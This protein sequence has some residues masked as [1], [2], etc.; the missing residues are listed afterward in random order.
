MQHCFWCGKEID[1]K[2][3]KYV[4]FQSRIGFDTHDCYYEFMRRISWR[5]SSWVLKEGFEK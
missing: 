5:N 4:F 3:K 1:W 2:S